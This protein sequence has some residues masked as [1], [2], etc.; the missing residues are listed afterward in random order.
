MR[1]ALGRSPPSPPPCPSAP[2]WDGEPDFVIWPAL[3]GAPARGS[4]APGCRYQLPD[5]RNPSCFQPLSTVRP[6]L[7]ALLGPLVPSY[8]SQ[9]LS[10]LGLGRVCL[11]KS[12]IHY[13]ACPFFSFQWVHPP[14]F[15][16]VG[17]GWGRVRGTLLI[18]KCLSFGP[19]SKRVIWEGMLVSAAPSQRRN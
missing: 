18:V 11:G 3:G 13:F 14:L 4:R 17:E 5:R 16:A 7:R 8:R 1:V 9:S 6:L 2:A 15:S 19:I 10:L 12:C